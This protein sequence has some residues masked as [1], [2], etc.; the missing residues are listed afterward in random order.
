MEC[1][2]AGATVGIVEEGVCE[3]AGEVVAEEG[4]VE[5]LEHIRKNNCLDEPHAIRLHTTE[6]E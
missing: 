3:D 1:K 5:G 4:A 2:I 6:A